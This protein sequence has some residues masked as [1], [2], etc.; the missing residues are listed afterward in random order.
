M[1][2]IFCMILFFTAGIEWALYVSRPPNKDR[3]AYRDIPFKPPSL[4]LKA[5]LGEPL[6]PSS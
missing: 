4:A 3:T 6:P 2:P 5:N 1:T